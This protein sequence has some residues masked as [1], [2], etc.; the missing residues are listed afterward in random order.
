MKS[1]FYYILT[2][3]IFY[4]TMEPIVLATYIHYFDKPAKEAGPEMGWL[5]G[6][7]VVAIA[8]TNVIILHRCSLGC[9]RIGMRV[10]IACCSLI[11]RKVS[12]FQTFTTL[13]K[14]LSHVFNHNLIFSWT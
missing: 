11:Y 13:S 7:G 2:Q 3:I 1:E 14:L 10:R 6:T 5:L 8:L 9:Q 4:R 12:S